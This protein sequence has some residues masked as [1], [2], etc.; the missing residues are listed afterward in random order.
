MKDLNRLLFLFG[1]VLFVGPPRA[2]DIAVAERRKGGELSRV[3]V[4]GVVL[5]EGMLRCV[6]LLGIAV[7]FEQLISPYWYAWLEIDRSAFIMLI[8]GALHMM[9]YYLIL[10]RFHKRLGA[11]AFKLYRFMRNIGYALLP[12]LAVVTVGLLYD[13]QLVVSE[14]TLQQQYLVYSVVTAIML[15]IGLLEAVLVSRNPQGLDSYL[16]RRAELAQ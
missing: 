7:A 16:N 10:H 3:P 2:L 1:Y 4:W 13:A 9:S 8:V 15:V 14:F 5:V 6:L 11:R 12:G